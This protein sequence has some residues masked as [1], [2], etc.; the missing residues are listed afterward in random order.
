MRRLISIF[1]L[2][3]S[4]ALAESNFKAKLQLEDLLIWKISDEL[5]LTTE[6][7]KKISDI[8]KYLNKKKSANS[9]E[10]EVL[11]QRIIKSEDEKV[12]N[13]AF[14]DLKKKLSIY[15]LISIEEL[16]KVKG[17]L[18]IKKLG[19]YLELKKDISEKVK[20]IILPAD[21][22]GEVKLPPPKITEE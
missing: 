12:K 6:Q 16:D 9:Q 5:K 13:K 22:K 3:F 7:E 21:K 19:Q 15:N 17:V 11:T 18:G 4:T 1:F 10:I 8:I 2:M 20:N 14:L